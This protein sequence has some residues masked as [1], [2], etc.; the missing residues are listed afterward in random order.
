[1]ETKLTIETIYSKEFFI[2]MLVQESN[3]Y[4]DILK[5]FGQKES[6]RWLKELQVQQVELK[7]EV[8]EI[9]REEKEEEKLKLKLE[10]EMEKE[11]LKE[12]KELLKAQKELEKKKEKELLKAQKEAERERI[13]EEK[14]LEKERLQEEK[15]LEKEFQKLQQIKALDE[16]RK[17][18][19]A[20][21]IIPFPEA[22]ST[23]NIIERVLEDI[24][25]EFPELV[26]DLDMVWSYDDTQG[27][28]VEFREG[29]IRDMIMSYS[30]FPYI[31]NGL[32]LKKFKLNALHISG[33]I[34]EIIA[35]LK[36]R[37]QQPEFF[38]N[39][40][41]MGVMMSNG[42]LKL[43]VRNQSIT[44]EEASPDH[45]ARTSF[46]VPFIPFGYELPDSPNWDKFKESVSEGMADTKDFSRLLD[47]I[48]GVIATGIS[49]N[50]QV[51][52]KAVLLYGGKGT[53]KSTYLEILM[54]LLP[55][56]NSYCSI[57]PK[58]FGTATEISSLEGKLLNISSEVEGY[59]GD[60]KADFKNII[61]GEVKNGRRLYGQS[62]AF[63]PKALHVF[64]CNDLPRVSGTDAAYWD[65]W[66][67][68]PF[69]NRFRGTNDDV[70][71]FHELI[72]EEKVTIINLGIR[73]VLA[74][75]KRKGYTKIASSE[76]L[77]NEWKEEDPMVQFMN[78]CIESLP[79]NAP[80][81]MRIKSS[82]V[83]K[84]YRR[85]AK[86]NGF[87]KPISNR[88]FKKILINEGIKETVTDGYHKMHIVLKDNGNPITPP[89]FDALENQLEFNLSRRNG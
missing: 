17:A 25:F 35:N 8:E 85:W 21:G 27:I 80:R 44:L 28:W 37:Y 52:G 50:Q 57:H 54:G 69:K 15:E 43:D 39:A 83:Y 24:S 2:D 36:E 48:T 16:E 41:S 53:G 47:E 30:D 62:F 4:N 58:D 32:T 23:V 12:E 89:E 46:D 34:K 6:L 22:P 66:I 45:R 71:K 38:S 75:I 51:A 68:L 1:M 87:S 7:D 40:P 55:D 84:F 63:R 79:E 10:K 72:L 31:H 61:F 11:K 13:K 19:E 59:I 18:L 65:R 49:T 33:M 3:P 67:I 74:M 86:E 5:E 42:F 20:K 64:A 76:E 14:E 29:Q 82:L 81:G 56:K 60:V 9:K 88:Q 26:Y 73:A 78:E 77:M 70:Y